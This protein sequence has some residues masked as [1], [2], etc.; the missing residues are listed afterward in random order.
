MPVYECLAQYLEE[1]SSAAAKLA[2]V[3]WLSRSR[4][5]SRSRFRLR[6][7]F[8]SYLVFERTHKVARPRSWS[9]ADQRSPPTGGVS[10]VS[11]ERYLELAFPARPK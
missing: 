7:R 11:R 4:S 5:R 1:G 8:R 10:G 6:F 3:I 9:I 2:R